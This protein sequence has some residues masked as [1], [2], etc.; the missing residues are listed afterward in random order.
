MVDQAAGR[1][2]I[3]HHAVFNNLDENL[4][5]VRRAEAAGADLVLL[6]YPPYFHPSSLDEVYEYT[7]AICDATNLAVILFPDTELGVLAPAPRRHP[8][9]APASPHRR[10]PQHRRDQSRRRQPEHHGPHRSP[11]CVPREVVISCPMEHEYIPLAQLI[12]IPFCGTNYGAY[13]GDTLSREF[14]P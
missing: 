6:G 14:T 8:G 1:L 5:A 13:F 10:L 9:A 2:L 3:I 11:S 4:D 12:P 7:K